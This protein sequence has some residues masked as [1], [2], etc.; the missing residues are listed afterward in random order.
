MQN[1]RIHHTPYWDRIYDSIVLEMVKIE[2]ALL[3]LQPAA[4]QIQS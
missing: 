2:K 3:P 4:Q 1:K